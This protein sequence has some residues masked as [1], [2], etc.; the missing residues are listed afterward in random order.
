MRMISKQL[1]FV[2]IP[3]RKATELVIQNHYLHR[4]CQ[5]SWCWG[6]QQGDDILGV[7]TIGRP[8]TWSAMAGVVGETY[9]QQKGV[10][11]RSKDVYELNRLWVHDSLPRN[12]ESRFIAWCLREVRKK[13]PQIILISYADGMSG[14]VGY[15]Y[16]ATNWLYLGKSADFEDITPDG[17]NDCRSAPEEVRGGVVFQCLEDGFFEGPL[18]P[19]SKA[20][21]RNLPNVPLEFPCP[22]CGKL[23]RKLRARAWAFI[24]ENDGVLVRREKARKWT[25]ILLDGRVFT[26][27]L[28][29]R[30]GKHQYA[31][32]GRSE[33]VSLLPKSPLPY[34]KTKAE[35]P[36]EE[37]V[38]K[39]PIQL[40]KKYQKSG[41]SAKKQKN[42]V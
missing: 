10:F 31:W 12:T 22:K 35:Q 4:R 16:Q 29:K 17:I 9:I 5:I 3:E 7:L 23:S 13:H 30:T 11:S 28:K 34:P 24:R 32:F 1:I 6:I 20:K 18:P 42:M 33:D 40:K 15:V 14:H 36:D 26:M 19:K 27:R 21:S 37:N 41:K 39:K 2:E 8:A 25:H 38:C